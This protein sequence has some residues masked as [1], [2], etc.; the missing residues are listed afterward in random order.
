[1][2]QRNNERPWGEFFIFIRSSVVHLD[3]EDYSEELLHQHSFAIKNQLVASKA[4]YC[5]SLV[6]YGIRA[7]IIGS[8]RA[9]K[10]PILIL[11]EPARSKQK[12]PSKGLW[13]RWAGSLW[14][15]RHWRSNTMKLSTNESRASLDLD[16]WEWTTLI[17][18]H[19][20]GRGTF[21]QKIIDKDDFWKALWIM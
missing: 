8:F 4:P 9:G 19:W 11:A 16:Q 5:S 1:M 13:M 7:P 10:P 17:L 18:L 12:A 20:A 15:K 21:S 14:H 6:L 2:Q 3:D